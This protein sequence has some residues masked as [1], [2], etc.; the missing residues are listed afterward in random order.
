MARGNNNHRGAGRH[1]SPVNSTP[2]RRIVALCWTVAV[3]AAPSC[4]QEDDPVHT[5]SQAMSESTAA[6]EPASREPEA[7]PMHPANDPFVGMYDHPDDAAGPDYYWIGFLLIEPPCAF[8][9][10]RT[11]GGSPGAYD[12]YLVPEVLTLARNTTRYNPSTRS[13]QTGDHEPVTDGDVVVV[14]P[15]VGRANRHSKTCPGHT[16]T[17]ADQVFAADDAKYLSLEEREYVELLRRD[18]AALLAS[19]VHRRPC[20]QLGICP[21]VASF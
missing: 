9:V 16:Q 13:I 3:L 21:S 4:S 1:P 20:A 19:I 14:T 17:S 2:L 15:G 6:P 11:Y 5:P 18:A 10:S 8:L 12:S 7:P